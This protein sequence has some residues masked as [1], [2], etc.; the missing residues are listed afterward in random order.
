MSPVIPHVTLLCYSQD[1]LCG[2]LCLTDIWS[3]FFIYLLT[4]YFTYVCGVCV[5]VARD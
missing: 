1:Y 3:V 5:C 2:G 4:L